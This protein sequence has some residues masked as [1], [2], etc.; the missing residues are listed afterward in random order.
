[1]LAFAAAFLGEDCVLGVMVANHLD[2]R[3]LG[4]SVDAAH[5][6]VAALLDDLERF[7][8]IDLARNQVARASGRAHCDVEHA[9][10]G[11]SLRCRGVVERPSGSPTQ[12]G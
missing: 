5:V 7:E 4:H 3:G 1:V 8:L 12:E 11:G 10:H 2:D 6:L 9:V